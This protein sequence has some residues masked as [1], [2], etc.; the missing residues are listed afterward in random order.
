ML[1]RLMLL[2]YLANSVEFTIIVLIELELKEKQYFGNIPFFYDFDPIFKKK[3]SVYY[4]TSGMKKEKFTL[5]YKSFG[6]KHMIFSASFNCSSVDIS[7]F[8]HCGNVDTVLSPDSCSRSY[9]TIFIYYIHRCAS[10]T[11]V[12]LQSIHQLITNCYKNFNLKALFDN[13]TVLALL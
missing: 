10:S 4:S 12:R 9:F 8:E 6:F 13:D 7:V 2:H 11:G 5:P 1:T 3:I